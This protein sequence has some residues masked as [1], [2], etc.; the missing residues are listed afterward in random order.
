M[1]KTLIIGECSV[2]KGLFAG[3]AYRPGDHILTFQGHRVD[4]DDPIHFT[5]EAANLLQTGALTYIYPQAPGV[6]ANHSC[7]PNAGITV[8]RRLIAIRPITS[9]EEIRFDYSTT[10]D[11]DLWQMTCLCGEPQCRGIVSDF[12]YLPLPLQTQYMDL[13][14]VPGFIARRCRRGMFGIRVIRSH[15]RENPRF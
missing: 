7:S 13:G 5:P 3:R 4:R 8:R 10:M 14:I 1:N 9:G 6:F 15:F 11:E 2:G 12:K